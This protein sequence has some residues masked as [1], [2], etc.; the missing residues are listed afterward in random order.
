[1]SL[2][3]QLKYLPFSH[4]I[5]QQHDTWHIALYAVTGIRNKC[6]DDLPLTIPFFL[7]Y[8]G[9]LNKIMSNAFTY[10]KVIMKNSQTHYETLLKK[11]C[12]ILGIE[13]SAPFVIITSWPQ[14]IPFFL[15]FQYISIGKI[16]NQ[17]STSSVYINAW[18]LTTSFYL[19]FQCTIYRRDKTD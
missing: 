7:V 6:M 1:M 16:I 15:I 10:I 17:Y 5:Y 14:T 13:F 11:I 2:L 3:A 4:I 12:Q 9:F 8:N 18:P 19:E